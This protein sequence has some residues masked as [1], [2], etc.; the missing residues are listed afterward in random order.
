MVGWVGLGWGDVRSDGL[1]GGAQAV[2]VGRAA[3]VELKSRMLDNFKSTNQR[4][5]DAHFVL[6]GAQAGRD[7]VVSQALAGS[8]VG[9]S[10][11]GTSGGSADG[12]SSESD[13]ELHFEIIKKNCNC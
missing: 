6:L 10:R 11:S 12:E 9:G 8:R 7:N 4:K 3:S 13:E 2:V 5:A 1:L